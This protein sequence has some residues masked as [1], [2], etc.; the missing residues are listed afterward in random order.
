MSK[1]IFFIRQALRC[2]LLLSLV[3]AIACDRCYDLA[4]QLCE[5]E[6]T[7]ERRKACK[8]NLSLAKSHKFFDLARDQQKCEEAQQK[9]GC[10]KMEE[11]QDEECGL[12]RD[13][14][15]GG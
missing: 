1:K 12:Y 3:N 15:K 9:C 4:A 5:C 7:E 6:K 10:K 14:L 8:T 13:A 2:A 11:G